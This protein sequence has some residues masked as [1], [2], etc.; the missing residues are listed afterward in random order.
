M[1]ITM[2]I[3]FILCYVKCIIILIVKRDR[4][5]NEVHK[6][7]GNLQDTVYDFL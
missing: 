1:C 7:W 4:R 2:S 6:T 5:R 3:L